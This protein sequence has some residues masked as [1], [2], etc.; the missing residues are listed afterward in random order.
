MS[1]NTGFAPTL[2]IA[3]VVET[4]VCPTVNTSSPGPMSSAFKAHTKAVVPDPKPAQ[5]SA[6]V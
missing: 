5:S 4:N 6:P 1:I 2:T 3:S